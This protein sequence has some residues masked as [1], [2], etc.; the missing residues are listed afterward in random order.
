[1]TPRSEA[2]AARAPRISRT[3]VFFVV[4]ALASSGA[5]VWRRGAGALLEAGTS[6]AWL[7]VSIAPVLAAALLLGGYV[8][9]LLPHERV[10]R[11]LGPQSG[12]RGL[13]LATLGGI[14]TPA[15]PFTVFP[16]VLGLRHAGAGFAVCVVYL[17]AWATLGLQR[18]VVWELPF[19]GPDF[20]ALRIAASL[21]LP[22]LAGALA[23]TL[24]R[25]L[26]R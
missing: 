6:A 13:G 12:W 21:P 20:V 15:G 3:T 14:V 8:N 26:D 17:T 10:A 9:A 18:V 22:L 5:L 4:L 19:L 16:V 1:M 11:W 24:A 25:H 7:L 2:I 23:S